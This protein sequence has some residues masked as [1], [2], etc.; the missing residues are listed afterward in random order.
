MAIPSGAAHDPI[1]SVEWLQ[2]HINDDQIRIID[3]RPSDAYATGHLPSAILTDLNALRM[4]DSSAATIERFTR[5]LT[6][7][8]RRLGV[9]PGERVIFYEDFSGALAP[10]GVWLLDLAGHGGGAMLD[11]GFSAWE[12]AGG[13]IEHRPVEPE[14]SDFTPELDLGRL[15]TAD[16]LLRAI[17][18]HDEVIPLDARAVEEYAAGTIPGAIHVD[19]RE[20]L[21]ENGTFRDLTDLAD[22]YR[23]A[24]L[25]PKIA[26]T[27]VPFCGSGFRAAN[28]YVVLKALGFPSVA[29]Y[30]PSW[31]EWGR[32]GDLPVALPAR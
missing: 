29:N 8:L 24:G 7:E 27:V 6:A 11:G 3:V 15:A 13:P 16:T 21:Q 26:A 18:G 14:S 5:L 23:D 9:R 1:V 28:S 2:H 17:G 12:A 22:L 10:R 30:A 20:H 19:W 31:G 25:T 4:P 32:R